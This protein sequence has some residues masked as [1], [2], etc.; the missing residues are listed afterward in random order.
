[1][2]DERSDGTTR[3]E[4]TGNGTSDRIDPFGPPL[5]TGPPPVPT[6]QPSMTDKLLMKL[7]AEQRRTNALIK[8][9]NDHLHRLIFG[10]WG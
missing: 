5:L 1:M 10:S 7:I 6:I 8:D 2:A 4:R 3:G 9:T